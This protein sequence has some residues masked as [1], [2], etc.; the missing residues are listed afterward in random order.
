MKTLSIKTAIN[1]FT[2]YAHNHFP[3][4]QI[5]HLTMKTVKLPP[6]SIIYSE[7]VIRAIFLLSSVRFLFQPVANP[8]TGIRLRRITRNHVQ[9]RMEYRSPLRRHPRPRRNSFHMRFHIN[10]RRSPR[11]KR[12]IQRTREFI[13]FIDRDP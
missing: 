3:N 12:L 10:N 13:R 2:D 7:R 9:M 6:F 4:F 8:F 11:I 5:S 1:P